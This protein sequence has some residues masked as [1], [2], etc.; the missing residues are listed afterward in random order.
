MDHLSPS[1]S[2][3]TPTDV[4]DIFP[5]CCP[6]AAARLNSDLMAP[7]WLTTTTRC[8]AM[9]TCNQNVRKSN[10][11]FSEHNWKQLPTHY[12]IFCVMSWRLRML[13]NGIKAI[14]DHLYGFH[15]FSVTKTYTVYTAGHDFHLH[16]AQGVTKFSLNVKWTNTF[17]YLAWMS[18]ELYI[19]MLNAGSMIAC[20]NMPLSNFH[21][22][23][24]LYSY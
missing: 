16:P 6:L 5:G 20:T 12:F 11:L 21:K 4:L 7:P 1:Y 19:Q 22:L 9:T 15:Q 23:V 13:K 8:P 24:T 10:C 17:K 2:W 14:I 3:I 18:N